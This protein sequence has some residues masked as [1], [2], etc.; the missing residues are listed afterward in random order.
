[1]IEPVSTGETD[2]ERIMASLS[3]SRRSGRFHV[4]SVAADDATGLTVGSGIEALIREP[5]VFGETVTVV[6]DAATATRNGWSSAI[7][8]AWLTLDVHTSMEAIGLT[9]A[10]SKALG[11]ARIPCNVLAGSHHDHILVPVDDADRA[12]D[13]LQSLAG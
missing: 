10:I 13:V 3:V 6:C 4:V 8:A 12:I 7:T 1:M 11:A 9:A 2:L 5:E